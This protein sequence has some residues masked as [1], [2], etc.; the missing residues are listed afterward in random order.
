M[1]LENEFT[2]N[3]PVEDAW[4]VLLD[5]E[6]VTPCL[7]GAAL[8]EQSDDD[9]YKGEMKVRLGPVTQEYNGTVRI[10]EADE[11]E[12]RAV[13]KADGK[14]A[15]G[16]GAATATITSTLYDEGDGSTKVRVETDMR[17]T[18]RAAQFGRGVQQDVAERLLSRF[19][20]CLENEIVGGGAKEEAEAAAT[21]EAG[22]SENGAAAEGA[23]EEEEQP[24]RRIIQQDREV[25]PLDLGEA[26]RDAV[27]K[28][29]KQAAPVA[30]GVVALVVVIWL[31][32]RK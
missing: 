9:E 23:S 13:L 5:L 12:H 28:R 19:A 11:S 18:G 20:E 24:R 6:R 26:S 31:V 7:P 4:N 29:V 30:A 27:L 8:T 16:Q 22:P 3:V 21:S 10:E 14:D 25:E 1:K 32:R 15:R 17:I 2:V